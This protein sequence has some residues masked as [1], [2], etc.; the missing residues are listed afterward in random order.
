MAEDATR[1]SSVDT[2]FDMV[3]THT[4]FVDAIKAG[5]TTYI[6]GILGERCLFMTIAALCGH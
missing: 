6:E 4:Q 1:E 3:Q 5:E 2:E